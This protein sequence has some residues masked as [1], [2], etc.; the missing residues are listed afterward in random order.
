M[1]RILS[2]L[3]FGLMITALACGR[4]KSSQ[5]DT[6]LNTDLSLA[7]QQRGYLPIDSLADTARSGAA[8][9]QSAA[10]RT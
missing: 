8:P 10:R 9:A 3:M 5:Q 4:S 6:T 2:S 1:K 7:A